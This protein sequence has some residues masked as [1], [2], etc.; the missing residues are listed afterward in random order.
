MLIRLTLFISLMMSSW[1]LQA[2]ENRDAE[3]EQSIEQLEK[4]MYKPFVEIYILNE[5]KELRENHITLRTELLDTFNAKELSVS[6]RAVQYTADTTNVVFYMITAAASLLV[7]IGWKSLRDIRENI[8]SVTENKISSLTHEYEIRL[9]ELEHKLK[10]RSEEIIA[11]QEKITQTNQ[12]HSLWMRAGLEKSAQERL[13]IFDQILEFQPDDVE[14]MTYKADTLLDMGESIWAMS[15]ATQ[16][17]EQ[18]PDYALAYWQ[19]ACAKA[20][21][22]HPDEAI[23]DI[24]QALL[25]ADNLREELKNE[26]FFKA[27]D[28]FEEFTA[29]KQYQ[30]EKV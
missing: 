10:Q 4:P 8:E 5:L 21:M 20:E 29:L 13:S 25:L 26:P 6:D 3:V 2:A 14:A 16:A 1:L 12:I 19:R 11:T 15:L 24:K 28:P 27:L 23:E 30:A 7:L 18:N 17:I 9:S 22:N